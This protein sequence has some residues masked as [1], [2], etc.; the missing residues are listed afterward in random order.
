M[1]KV[2]SLKKTIEEANEAEEKEMKTHP[3]SLQAATPK[4]PPSDNRCW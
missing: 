1:A 3:P 4:P 2:L